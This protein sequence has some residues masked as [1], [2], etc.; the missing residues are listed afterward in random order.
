MSYVHS[1]HLT[2]EDLRGL[3]D[4]PPGYVVQ[5]ALVQHAGP[6]E[7][8]IFPRILSNFYQ[9]HA[10]ILYSSSYYIL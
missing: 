1:Y 3:C 2:H 10:H 5:E 7:L 6:A 8:Y 9:N 4:T